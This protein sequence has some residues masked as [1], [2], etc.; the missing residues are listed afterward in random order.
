MTTGLKTAIQAV[1][2]RQ[3]LDSRGTPTVEVDVRLEGGAFGRA[4]V[5]SGASTGRFEAHEL[6]DGQ[7]A[8]GG[9]GVRRA[10]DNIHRII[11]PK[12]QGQDALRQKEIDDLLISLDGTE[13]KARLGA[14][15]I[16]GVSLAV[17]RA[18]KNALRLP[19]YRYL[20]GLSAD[21]LPVPLL[22]ILNGGRHA[23]NNVAVQEFMIVPHGF[24]R[25]SDALEAS[26]EVYQ[27]L[28]ALLRQQG[29]ATG[30]GD[31]G[32]F[33]PDLPHD[34][35]ALELLLRAIELAGFRAGEEISL[36]LDFA[37]NE[38]RQADGTYRLG[39][40]QLSPER[41]QETISGWVR[42]FPIV[43]LED[44]AAEDDQA[45]WRAL[46]DELGERVQL[47]GDDLFV[48][49]AQRLAE[50]A[51]NRLANAILIKPNQIGTLSETLETVA[52]ARRLGYR[53]IISHRSGET[54]DAFIAD[55]AVAVGSWQ[56]KTGAPARSERVAKYNRLLEIEE[57]LG[58]GRYPGRLV[59]D[60][61]RW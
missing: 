57:E 5:P 58:P 37:G 49:N 44:P 31:E 53:T 17:C 45:L 55:L 51:R 6:R 13:N 35:A 32:G 40:E 48:T 39:D 52:L 41:Y 1:Y 2:A 15:A 16:L 11:A 47:V 26:V 50:G 12:V 46:T 14:N 56:I 29:L 19:L 38:L 54:E 4:K 43:S 23:D 33:A 36:A 3:I 61:S 21:T 25:F 24:R 28:K 9:K 22:N 18:A 10:I 27:A 59:Y 8:Y 60:A 34:E 20:G 30:V 42:S 7:K